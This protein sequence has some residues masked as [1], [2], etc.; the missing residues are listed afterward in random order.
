MFH[1]DKLKLRIH[2]VFDASCIDC[3]MLIFFDYISKTDD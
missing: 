2:F 3:L 1:I